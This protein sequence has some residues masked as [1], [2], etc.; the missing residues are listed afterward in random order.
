MSGVGVPDMPE[1]D[2]SGIK[3]GADILLEK[4]KAGFAFQML[5]VAK[6]AGNEIVDAQNR[7]AFGDQGVT[8][9]G[10]EKTRSPCDHSLKLL[11]S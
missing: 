3:L 7:M 8:K 10:A 4:R 5:E 6:F 9:M 11:G 2:A 1:L